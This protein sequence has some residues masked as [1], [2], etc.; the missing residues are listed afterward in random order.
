MRLSSV[1]LHSPVGHAHLS[2]SRALASALS[3]AWT[4]E[5][6]DYLQF[7]PAFERK[8]WTGLYHTALRHAPSLWRA[9]RRLTDRP[10]EPRFM[11]DR[12]SAT[13]AAAFAAVLAEL[14]PRLV[15]STIGGAA[16]LAGAARARSGGSFLNAL[17]VTHFRAHR[18]WARPEADLVFVS[19]DE[20]RADLARHGIEPARIIVAGTPIR[21]GLRAL[22]GDA[23]SALRARLGLGD[24]PVIAVSSGGTGAYRAHD[25]LLALLERLGRPLDVLVFKGSAASIERRGEL[26]VHRLG[27][28]ADFTDWL[29]ASDACV[30]KLGSLTAA[31]ACAL[32]V[33]IVVW[34]PIPGAEEDNAAYLVERGAAVW[35]RGI[36]ELGA[37]V[38]NIL[39]GGGE[40]LARA[41]AA[42]YRPDAARTIARILE[43]RTC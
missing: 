25:Q 40:H 6:L 22:D 36:R 21:A 15:V 11:R 17:V 30:G 34:Q 16:A 9:W 7:M 23:R 39:D 28:R 27:F 8:L 1:F 10:S 31:E 24:D 5:E 2:A 3:P 4:R 41:A 43:E 19:T 13:G 29:A 14:E 26:R 18:H 37:V 20:A 32:H 12:V 35:P 38:G 33:P 42:L